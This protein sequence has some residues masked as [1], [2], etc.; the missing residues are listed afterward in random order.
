MTTEVDSAGSSKIVSQGS[1]AKS[2]SIPSDEL[3]PRCNDV[4]D[5]DDEWRC[6]CWWEV[7]E[8]E[9]VLI[10][11]IMTMGTF[12]DL[13]SCKFGAEVDLGLR[14]GGGGMITAESTLC[15]VVFVG[16]GTVFLL[17]LVCTCSCW[18]CGILTTSGTGACVGPFSRTP[19][20]CLAIIEHTRHV[21]GLLTAASFEDE[22]E[23]H[24]W[25]DFCCA[26]AIMRISRHL[27]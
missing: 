11:F 13:A 17:L 12:C 22:T 8:L 3:L 20:T 5:N 26:M 25:P 24:V 27:R 10:L 7:V 6:L 14:G 4:Y 18:S 2:H 15:K 16:V 9:L 21:G 1:A 23:R 19:R